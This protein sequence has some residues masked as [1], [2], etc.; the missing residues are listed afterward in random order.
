VQVR[1]LLVRLA[2]VVA[3]RSA[4]GDKVEAALKELSRSGDVGAARAARKAVESSLKDSARQLKALQDELEA[5]G[6][7][8]AAAKV[9]TQGPPGGNIFCTAQLCAETGQDQPS[10]R[11]PVQAGREPHHQTPCP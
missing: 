4:E 8:K 10:V 9:R 11:G 2:S 7:A 3:A 1:D 5:A 6:D